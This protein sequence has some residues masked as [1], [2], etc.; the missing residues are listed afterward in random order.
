MSSTAAL[1]FTDPGLLSVER[2]TRPPRPR[3]PRRSPHKAVHNLPTTS[4]ADYTDPLWRKPKAD[5]LARRDDDKTDRTA[6]NDGWK[7]PETALGS[8]VSDV[9]FGHGPAGPSGLRESHTPRH[10]W[11]PGSQQLFIQVTE[12][13]A[14]GL[15]RGVVKRGEGVTRGALVHDQPVPRSARADLLPS[16]PHGSNFDGGAAPVLSDHA[17]DGELAVHLVGKEEGMPGSGRWSPGIFVASH[18][19]AVGRGASPDGRRTTDDHFRGQS[20]VLD[21]VKAIAAEGVVR[22]LAPSAERRMSSFDGSSVLTA[23]DAREFPIGSTTSTSVGGGRR[24]STLAR[25]HPCSH[26][27]AP[28]SLI[29]LRELAE[30]APNAK[31]RHRHGGTTDAGPA[32]GGSTQQL[33]RRSSI[34]GS[35]A[36]HFFG[37][38]SPRQRGGEAA[39]HGPPAAADGAAGVRNADRASVWA[40]ERTQAP[41]R[42]SLD[43]KGMSSVMGGTL[44]DVVTQEKQRLHRHKTMRRMSFSGEQ[45]AAIMGGAGAPPAVSPRL[46]RSASPHARHGIT[47]PGFR[48]RRDSFIESAE[49]DG[50]AYARSVAA[51]GGGEGGGER[52]GGMTGVMVSTTSNVLTAPALLHETRVRRDS[53]AA[54][55]ARRGSL[56]GSGV[57][58]AAG[59][60]VAPVDRR[61]P[62]SAPSGGDH[63][64]QSQRAASPVLPLANMAI[65]EDMRSDDGA[66]AAGGAASTAERRVSKASHQYSSQFHTSL[67]ALGSEPDAKQAAA[68]QHRLRREQ[69]THVGP[70]RQARAEQAEAIAEQRHSVSSAAV[71]VGGKRRV[72]VIEAV[73]IGR[74]RPSSDSS[75]MRSLLFFDC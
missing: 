38:K 75:R 29:D 41:R 3:S 48:K 10:G 44:L 4:A 22:Q 18:D 43:G 24:A 26:E 62:S 5:E 68:I 1:Q 27:L 11:H 65:G 8:A 70:D 39:L 16:A 52:G 60:G 64:S 12:G 71:A 19:H 45:A 67:V 25:G 49:R 57:V 55:A 32:A 17:R 66:R 23:K 13:A 34:Y 56:S 21:D 46:G 54:A 20:M 14:G 58:I 40:S 74:N 30:E 42:I 73:E 2:L 50:A 47:P 53:E 7:K 63:H 9:V 37:E 28:S 35:H 59:S 33:M 61:R 6:K 15:P 72:S 36:N 69:G 51:G 31:A